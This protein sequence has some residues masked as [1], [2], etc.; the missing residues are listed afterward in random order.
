LSTNKQHSLYHDEHARELA[1]QQQ[2]FNENPFIDEH[3]QILWSMMAKSDLQED[4]TDEAASKA[5]HDLSWIDL[6]EPDPK[7]NGAAMR[8]E[9]L[10]PIWKEEQGNEM[11][12][13]FGRGC[14]KKVKRSELPM[15][16]RVI[17]SRF[18]Y[19]IKRHSAGEHKLKVKRLKVR[20]VVQGHVVRAT[21]Q[22][23]SARFRTCLECDAA[24][25]WLLP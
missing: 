3:L 25:P 17:S 12:G 11:T 18:H 24:C 20:L 15:G 19:K 14:L 13:L 4:V 21:S 6:T 7:Y 16:T 8:N 9:R 23:L 22:T 1:T 2:D 10:A 5:F